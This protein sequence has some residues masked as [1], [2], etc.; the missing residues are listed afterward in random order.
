MHPI[1]M[2][3]ISDAQCHFVLSKDT[4]TST[5]AMLKGSVQHSYTKWNII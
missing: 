3:F 2:T 5:S 1:I 4:T